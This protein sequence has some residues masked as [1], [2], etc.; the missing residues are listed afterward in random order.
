MIY[1]GTH[2]SDRP[3]T[4]LTCTGLIPLLQRH[5]PVNC[6]TMGEAADDCPNHQSMPNHSSTTST[7]F[8]NLTHQCSCTHYS[9]KCTGMKPHHMH[10]GN[11]QMAT[12]RHNTHL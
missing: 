11:C 2:H 7:L 6:P 8:R 3:V 10:W 4:C 12:T 9:P 1:R 5:H